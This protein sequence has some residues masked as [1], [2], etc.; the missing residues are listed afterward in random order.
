[1]SLVGIRLLSINWSEYLSRRKAIPTSLYT[2]YNIAYI[3]HFVKSPP[4]ACGSFTLA[5][6]TLSSP[7]LAC[8]DPDAAHLALTN[9]QDHSLAAVYETSLGILRSAHKV[10]PMQSS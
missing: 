5:V 2:V 7:D 4:L 3:R 1:Q 8:I 10:E 9:A 6:H